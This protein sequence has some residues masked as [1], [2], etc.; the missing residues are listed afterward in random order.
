MKVSIFREGGSPNSVCLFALAP[1]LAIL[2]SSKPIKTKSSLL[3]F[4]AD[5]SNWDGGSIFQLPFSQFS[6][7]L[8]LFF[9]SLIRFSFL[10]VSGFRRHRRR[11]LRLV[12][13]GSAVIAIVIGVDSIRKYDFFFTYQ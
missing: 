11:F 1:G 4:V 5:A 10:L 12:E 6:L 7:F 2:Q 9:L 8:L 3:F 13:I